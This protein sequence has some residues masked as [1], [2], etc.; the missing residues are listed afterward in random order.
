MLIF[1]EN[2]MVFSWENDGVGWEIEMVF[3][4]EER[5]VMGFLRVGL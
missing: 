3:G 5:I 2:W 1:L 4:K